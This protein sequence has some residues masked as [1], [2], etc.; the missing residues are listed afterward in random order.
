VKMLRRDGLGTVVVTVE[1][2]RFNGIWDTLG[3]AAA[4]SMKLP[5]H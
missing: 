3:H 2:V 5:S 4:N 1:K